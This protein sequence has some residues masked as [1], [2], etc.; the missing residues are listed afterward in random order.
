MS[1]TI[2]KGLPQ[3]AE[4]LLMLYR[5]QLGRPGC[6]WD[7]EYP[8]LA[9]IRED[10]ELE[11]LYLLL[12]EGEL[13]AAASCGPFH[14]LDHLPL[15]R[16]SS[17]PFELARVCV[18][19]DRQG[20]GLAS[21]LLK[22]I[23]QDLPRRGCDGL[24]LLASLDNPPALR[25][26]E[27]AGFTR[28]GMA[29]AYDLDFAAYDIL[30]KQ[31]EPMNIVVLD[32]YA[33]NPGDLS[34]EPLKALGTLTLYDRTAPEEVI[35]RAKDAD[36]LLVNKVVLSR[37]IIEA[38]PN[39]KYVG[40][41]A[42]G[43]NNIDGAACRERGIPVCNIPAYSTPD[44]AQHVFALLLEIC[45]HAGGHSRL[46]HEGEW[47]KS[48]DFVFW[49]WPLIELRGLTLGLVGWGQIAKATAEIAKAFGMKVLCCNSKNE[50]NDVT[51]TLDKVLSQSDIVSL[52]CPLT[53][54]NQKMIN[55]ET[56]AK[57]KDGAILINTARGGLVDEQ[58]LADALRSGKLAFA[59]V[60]VVTKEPMD[61]S[62]PLLGIEN[63]LITPHIAWA[64][65][66]ARQ[67]LMDIAAANIAGFLKG[68]I[69]NQVNG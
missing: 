69:Q 13:V 64:P 35:S 33:A 27:R 63:C 55:A 34:W 54:T 29:H 6:A 45:M 16:K 49:R 24:R 38:L 11:A 44:V 2:R 30:L 9:N 17:R 58:A 28:Q 37:E 46:V 56:I 67:R 50:E 20:Q 65:K 8:C 48:P 31:E 36:M 3:D 12:D 59:G 52:H 25:L 1:I 53:A 60:D 26:Y 43:Y 32:A 15:W 61:A 4:A 19:P 39:L 5:Q 47:V 51:T 66:A 10:L 41:L 23:L 14:E 62:C 40:E 57:M 42:T 68:E 21:Q 18:R 7:E 22:A